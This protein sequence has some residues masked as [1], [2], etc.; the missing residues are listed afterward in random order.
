MAKYLVGNV[1]A[2]LRVSN[3]WRIESSYEYRTTQRTDDISTLS[4]EIID[5]QTHIASFSIAHEFTLQSRIM[6]KYQFIKNI[7][8]TGQNDYDAHMPMMEFSFKF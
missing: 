3:N 7:D 1:A 4:I 5:E 6:F 8:G 2:S